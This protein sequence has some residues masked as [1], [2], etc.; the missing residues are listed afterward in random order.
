[1]HT[2]DVASRPAV[3]SIS[4]VVFSVPDLDAAQVFYSAFGLD[5][6]REGARLDL[7][8]FGHQHR[9]IS[10]TANGQPKRLQYLQLGIYAEDEAAFAE[11]VAA[12]GLGCKPAVDAEPGGIWLRCPDGTL[13]QLLAGEKVSPSHKTR[14]AKAVKAAR[15]LG[16]APARSQAQQVRPR[17]L[18]HVLLFTPKLPQMLSFCEDVLGLRLSDRS[19]D[20]IAFMHSA[21]GS[22]HHLLA[23]VK[24]Q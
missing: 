2:P 20:V 1:M 14:P 6:R 10:I 23:L 13:L 17:A 16:A 8:T 7:Y 18:S 15:G 3:H 21:H 22:D 12:L 19:G 11:R 5:V 4:R 9:W 24:S